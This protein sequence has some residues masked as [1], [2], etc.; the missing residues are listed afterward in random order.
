MKTKKHTLTLALL[1]ALILTAGAQARTS[2]SRGRNQGHNRSSKF[3]AI[4]PGLHFSTKIGSRLH[5]RTSIL[6]PIRSS[7]SYNHH[8]RH[9]YIAPRPRTII[10]PRPAP[11]IIQPQ[12]VT[13]WI[14][15]PNGS[16]TPV[17]LTQEGPWYIGPRQERY[18]GLPTQDQLRPV[19]GLYC[20]PVEAIEPTEIT[21]YITANNGAKLPVTLVPTE[22]GYYGPKGEL[23]KNMP[24]EKQ[25][26]MLYGK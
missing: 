19:Y 1:I 14:A 6:P 24:T 16:Q 2:R 7:Y 22:E 4:G 17:S 23:Y 20:E 26:R 18:F 21:V 8:R 25:L 9:T 3:V 5:L 13:V 15:N 10:V 11:V 12:T